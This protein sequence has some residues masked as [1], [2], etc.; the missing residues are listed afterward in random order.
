MIYPQILEYMNS[1]EMKVTYI[2]ETFLVLLV[3][4]MIHGLIL[5]YTCSSMFHKLDNAV[6]VLRYIIPV[7]TR[8]Q[9]VVPSINFAIHDFQ[10]PFWAD[11][12]S[13]PTSQVQFCS[14]IG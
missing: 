11:F 7:G 3:P 5:L 8:F 13:E 1:A 4:G 6:L 9:K 10:L 2:Q 12:H 14:I